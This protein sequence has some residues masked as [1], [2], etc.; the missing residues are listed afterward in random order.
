MLR[1]DTLLAAVLW[2][3]ATI[4]IYALA[5][6]LHNRCRAWWSSPLLTAPLVLLVIVASLHVRYGEYIR[7]THWLVTLLA[8]ATVAFAV[9]IYEQRA[10]ILR[11]WPLLAVG[12]VVG[13][14]TAFFSSWLLANWLG[15][16]EQL[17]LSLLPR[18]MST[19]FAMTV[20]GDFGGAPSLTAVFV[21]IT[22]V[23]GAGIGEALL[24]ILPLRSALAR[25]AL[26]GM[27]AH[28]AG[29][30]KALQI[31]AEIGS[32]AGLVMV[33]VGLTNVLAAPLIAHWVSGRL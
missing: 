8:P 6:V 28:G 7:G 12:I 17:K 26:F 20:S 27:G 18:S 33:F 3:A 22:G 2:S 11:H 21:L 9:P 25:G 15:L 10:V 16:D 31:N 1:N 23:L 24:A 4:A 14:V 13:S 32:V 29:T 30:A 19:P 5:K